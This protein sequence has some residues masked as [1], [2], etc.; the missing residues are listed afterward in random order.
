MRA[1]ASPPSRTQ[2]GQ[3]KQTLDQHAS[4]PHLALLHFL[5]AID[6]TNLDTDHVLVTIIWRE[7]THCLG[8]LDPWVPCNS[9]FDSVTNDIKAG[10]AVFQNRCRVLLDIL[11]DTVHFTSD[12][13][14]IV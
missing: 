3:L 14:G 4:F 6:G 8:F 10:F 2:L 9:V 11:V 5:P 13:E 12:L 1:S 7:V